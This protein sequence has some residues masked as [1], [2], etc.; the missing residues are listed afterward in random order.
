MWDRKVVEKMEE[1]VGNFMVAF[2]FK[3]TKDGLLWPL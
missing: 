1:C 3:N 2:L